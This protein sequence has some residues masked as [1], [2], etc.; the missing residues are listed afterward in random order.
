MRDF[1][2]YTLATIT[3]IILASFLLF[4]LST[5]VFFG[6]VSSTET[7]VVIRDNSVLRL[8]LNGELKDRVLSDDTFSFLL[9]KDQINYGLEDILDAINKATTNEQ[10]KGI[11]IEAGN[12]STSYSSLWE[13]REA[14]SKFKE[15]GKFIISYAD[16][17]TQGL[18]YLAS[19]SNKVILNPQGMIYWAGLS[20]NPIY[21]KDLL[22]KIGVEMQVFKVGTYKSAV[23]PYISNEMS[24]CKK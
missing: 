19:V 11:Y 18:Y 15:A 23:E 8:K 9:G 14:L 13:I 20:S 3:G 16:H 2:K 5:I 22:S 4:F 7:E 21:F 24:Y 17:Y 1:I 10:I 6:L 12:L